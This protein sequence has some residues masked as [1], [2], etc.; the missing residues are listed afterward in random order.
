MRRQK[1]DCTK[2][3]YA[4]PTIDKKQKWWQSLGFLRRHPETI[5]IMVAAVIAVAI[6]VGLSIFQPLY[7]T[8]DVGEYLLLVA[9]HGCL[10]DGFVSYSEN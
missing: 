2:S 4:L 10:H 3:D 5:K 7:E 6:G 1:P 9:R 8:V